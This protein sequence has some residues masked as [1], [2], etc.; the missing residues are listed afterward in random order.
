MLAMIVIART[1]NVITIYL[2]IVS[3]LCWGPKHI[4]YH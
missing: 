3:N 4:G 1:L 2:P